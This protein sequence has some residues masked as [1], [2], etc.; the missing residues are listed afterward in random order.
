MLLV[1]AIIC[2]LAFC[3]LM[4]GRGGQDCE[5]HA[6]WYTCIDDT[7]QADTTKCRST[8]GQMATLNRAR[9]GGFDCCAPGEEAAIVKNDGLATTWIDRRTC[10]LGWEVSTDERYYQEYSFFTS[11]TT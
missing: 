4:L 1:T 8:D 3:A 9:R 6:L 7:G 11:V 10:A 5:S 2:A